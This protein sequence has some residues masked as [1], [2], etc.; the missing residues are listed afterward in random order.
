MLRRLFLLCVVFCASAVLVYTVLVPAR[1][2]A[3]PKAPPSSLAPAQNL[4]AAKAYLRAIFDGDSDDANNADEEVG[5][6]WPADA[7]TPE[8]VIYAQQAMVADAVAKLAP[9]TPGKV[10]LYLLGFA[11]DGE[12]NVFRNEVEYVAKLFDQRFDGS[13]HS[14]IL[15]NNPDTLARYPLASLSNLELAADAIAAKIDRDRDI[16]LLFL[17]T[18]GSPDHLLYVSMDPLPLDQIAPEDLAEVLAKTRVRY[19]VVVISACYSGGFVAALKSPTTLVITAARKDR[20][21]FGCGTDSPITDFGR[22]FFVDGLNQTGSLTSAFAAASK[23]ID[24][25][26]TR[27]DEKHSYPQMASATPIEAQLDRWRRAIRL[28]PPVPF[29]PPSKALTPTD[30]TPREQ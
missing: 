13:G 26:E 2:G 11:G 12:E 22:A 30:E 20:S 10:N 4:D 21:S 25:W 3:S 6:S 8:Q 18:H 23:L 19:K 14:L 7:K 16:L 9:P 5:D 15:A 17:T 27:D 29:K 1:T 28:G 24:Q